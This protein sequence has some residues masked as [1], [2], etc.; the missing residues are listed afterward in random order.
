MVRERR[1]E[2][3]PTRLDAAHEVVAL[4]IGG[5]GEA[6]DGFLQT[7]RTLQERRDVL[8]QDP[9]LG[10]VRH[11][12]D[13]ALDQGLLRGTRHMP[14]WK[15]FPREV[16]E[17]GSRKVSVG[18]GRG[19]SASSPRIVAGWVVRGSDHAVTSRK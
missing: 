8:E 7:R 17:A 11:I 4:R 9:L 2:D 16:D 1:A 18:N 13:V 5:G 15:G 14:T 10:E 19:L 3:E 6:G 12:A